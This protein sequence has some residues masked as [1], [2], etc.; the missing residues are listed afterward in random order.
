M[1]E[2]ERNRCLFDVNSIDQGRATGFIPC[3]IGACLFGTGLGAEIHTILYQLILYSPSKA[4][5]CLICHL[6]LAWPVYVHL[7]NTK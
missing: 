1:R 4:V 6:F 3:R 7:H 2:E 5:I